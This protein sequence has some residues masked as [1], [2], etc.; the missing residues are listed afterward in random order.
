MLQEAMQSPFI[1]EKIKTTS[2]GNRSYIKELFLLYRLMQK[3]KLSPAE[4][5]HY[6]VLRNK[7]QQE[8]MYLLK[9]TNP[10]KYQVFIEEQ[11]RLMQ[12]KQDQLLSKA[13]KQ[14]QLVEEER[15]EYLQWLALQKR[16]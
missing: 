7:Y 15:K 1:L 14:Q 10:V 3:Q 6:F 16:A 8:Y 11:E 2:W 4:G 5:Q 13:A 12:Q 9:E